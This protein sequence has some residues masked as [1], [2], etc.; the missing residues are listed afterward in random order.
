[1]PTRRQF[2]ATAGATAVALSVGTGTVAAD[3]HGSHKPTDATLTFDEAWLRQYRP[4]LKID[5]L[6]IQPTAQY[7]F[8]ATH[9]GESTDVAVFFTFYV[10]QRGT[11]AEDSHYLDREP[12]YVFVDSETGDIVEVV[13]SAYHWLAGKETDPPLYT[14]GDGNDHPVARVVGPW[15]HYYLEPGLW[16]FEDPEWV[17]LKDL[18]DVHAPHED[19][20]STAW[21]DNGWDENLRYGAVVDPWT[22][23]DADDWW[24]DG[25]AVSESAFKRLRLRLSSLPG[26]DPRGADQTDL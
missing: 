9:P 6:D 11:T 14:D 16:A 3:D 20:G 10:T 13:Y 25:F 8:R 5:Q 19:D 4:L 1:M 2:C 12:F 17:P 18:H 24:Q 21:L 15:N 22:M 7:G 26:V 23:Q